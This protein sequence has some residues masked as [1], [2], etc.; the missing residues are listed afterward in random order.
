M[1]NKI[2]K[3]FGLILLAFVALAAIGFYIFKSNINRIVKTRLD[4]ELA[5][6]VSF[7]DVGLSWLRDFPYVSISLNNFQIIGVGEFDGDTLLSAKQLGL[8]C[9]PFQFVMA[10]SLS[11]YS[12]N[13]SD[14]RIHGLILKN[15]HSNWDILKT[16]KSSDPIAT[17]GKPVKWDLKKYAIHNGYIKYEDETRNI[18]VETLGLEQEGKVGH[19]RGLFAVKTKINADAVQFMKGGSIPFHLN[20]K[21]RMD[22]AIKFDPK[23]REAT[24]ITNDIYLNELK[25]HSDF[26]FKWM[27]DSSYDMNINF[28]SP[29]TELKN[30]LSLLSPAYRRD[31]ESLQS[32][33]LVVLNGFVVGRYDS[34][35]SPAYHLNLDVKNGFCQYP[36]LPIALKNLNLAVNIDNPDGLEDHTL[37]NI[38]RAHVEIENDSLDF[39][40]LLK[41]PKSKPFIDMAFSGKMNL[42]NISRMMKLES[43]TRLSG[44]LDANISAKGNISDLGKQ[45]KNKFTAAGNFSLKDFLYISK[46]YP[47][48]IVLTDLLLTLNP[49]NTQI[50]ELKG[51]YLTTH[52]EATGAFSNAFEYAIKNE[53]LQASIDLKADEINLSQWL[54]SVRDSAKLHEIAPV[55]YALE[56]P[57]NINFNI[58]AEVENFHHGNLDMHNLSGTMAVIDETLYFKQIKAEALEGTILI[59]GTYSTKE[60]R[61]NPVIAMT[62]D[63]NG[64]DMQKTFL[65]FNTLQ[66]I[67][68]VGRFMTGKFNARMNVNGNLDQDMQPNYPTL[69]GDG[70]IVLTEGSLKAFGPIDKLSQTL[71]IKELKDI[72]LKDIHAD[73]SFEGGKV[74]LGAF[75]VHTGDIDMEVFGSH[76]FD[77][78]MAY[79]INLKVPRS[80]LG[81][82]GTAFVKNVVTDA[83]KKGIP[84]KLDESVNILV[85]LGGTIN[86]PDIKTDM[87]AVVDK[88]SEDLQKEMNDFVNAKLDSARQQLHKPIASKKSIFVQTSYKPK[89]T[90]KS[91][92]SSKKAHH[93]TSISKLKRKTNPKKKYESASLIRSQNLA[94]NHK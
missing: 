41:N 89:K 48:G 72:S 83:A 11:I 76:G 60:G 45:Q 75:P 82:K 8:A 35:H 25:L 73:F 57:A 36:D 40:L 29:T 33:G 1:K 78:A 94:S 24:F 68:P 5:A 92:K 56:V 12:I 22:L 43:G 15:G 69:H 19:I 46:D 66:K 71:D 54:G 79:D 50:N 47:D 87:S 90:E 49:K 67:M 80:E 85:K 30:V 84:V 81:Q 55:P 2:L 39:H 7:S 16:E 37:V 74:V 20:A 4:K 34:K 86:N 14:S 58:K 93:N 63:V 77:Q 70:N 38:H 13:I 28:R 26:Y 59:N 27:N 42:A 31:F 91:K 61:Q 52:F 21:A 62:Y 3:T 88:A 17:D 64:V 9:N 51:A 53:P 10:D 18:Q 32:S 6:H 44:M 65:A 23:R